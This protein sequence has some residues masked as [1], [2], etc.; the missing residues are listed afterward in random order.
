MVYVLTGC[1][2]MRTKK[3]G[4]HVIY[5]KMPRISIHTQETQKNKDKVIMVMYAVAGA[6]VSEHQ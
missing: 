4:F 2:L 6:P 1:F 5:W 3:V